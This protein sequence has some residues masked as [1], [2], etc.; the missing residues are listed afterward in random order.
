MLNS[1]ALMRQRFAP[2]DATPSTAGGGGR[3]NRPPPRGKLPTSISFPTDGS[4]KNVLQT[5]HPAPPSANAT[6]ST[7]IQTGMAR[8]LGSAGVSVAGRSADELT[9]VTSQSSYYAPLWFRCRA[10]V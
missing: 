3:R 7:E 5:N 10:V 9:V 4:A 8:T 2:I 6:I 1:P